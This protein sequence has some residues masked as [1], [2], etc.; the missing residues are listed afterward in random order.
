MR[1]P[2]MPSCR[3]RSGHR[4][5]LSDTI[6]I[7]IAISLLLT[8]PTTKA[9]GDDIAGGRR[10][11]NIV[12]I[13][14]DDLG[15]GDLGCYGQK[16][17]QTP[18]IDRMAAEGVRF[19]QAYAGSTVCAPSRS[20]LMSGMHNGRN[21]VRDNVPHYKEYFRNQEVTIAEVL[22][23]AGYRCGGVGKWS[24]GGAGSAG[25]ATNQGF[26]TWFGYLDQDDAHYYYPEALDDGEGEFE[27]PS[28]TKSHAFHSHELLT[29][30]VMA[31]IEKN[32][33]SPFFLYAAYTIPHWSAEEEDPTQF[34]VPSDAPYSDKPW[35]QR[36]KNYAAMIS[37]LDRDVGRI[38]AL[39]QALG[40]EDD[41]LVIFT[42]DNGPWKEAPKRF[43]SNGPLRGYKRDLYEGGIRVPFIARWPGRVPAGK[44]SDEIIAFWDLMPTFAELA[45]AECPVGINGKPALDAILGGKRKTPQPY[46]YW[47][48][49]HCRPRYMQAARM[50]RWKGI[51]QRAGE[52]VE[53]YDL[54]RDIGET[55][56][57]AAS[58]PEVVAKIEEIMKTAV[59]PSYR[60]PVGE[61]YE[62]GKWHIKE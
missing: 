51:R 39:L 4:L 16:D 30:R 25:R 20:C 18:H 19:T 62:K 46:L 13:V 49:G 38:L 2:P 31:F 56:D 34:P 12:L 52:S 33:K 42:S 8:L 3:I 45:G 11:P 27:M 7:T 41:T 36:E 32:Q 60:Y 40:L 59:T 14:A 17:I 50:G 22:K 54:K 6:A 57:V 1:L 58:H 47:D 5:S 35:T 9:A 28:N 24:L 23:T 43:D 26:D 37:W 10:P 55:E 48:Y 21:R 53:L 29:K 15:Y 44:T 61:I